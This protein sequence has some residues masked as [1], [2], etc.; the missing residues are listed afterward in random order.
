MCVTNN[1][2]GVAPITER[3]RPKSMLN[4]DAGTSLLHSSFS[5]VVTRSCSAPLHSDDADTIT[6]P[7]KC[8][9]AH[10]LRPDA[11][12]IQSMMPGHTPFSLARKLLQI[13]A[14]THT[15][16]RSVHSDTRLTATPVGTTGAV[17]DGEALQHRHCW[18]ARTATDAE[19]I[20]SACVCLCWCVDV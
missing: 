16:A 4:H 13:S 6:S 15:R 14:T 11:R 10:S 19:R 18:T 1:K 7:I 9:L 3:L 12:P 20:V 8:G 2:K 5:A 17:A